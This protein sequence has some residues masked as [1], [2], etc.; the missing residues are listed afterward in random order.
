MVI[1]Y[2][3]PQAMPSRTEGLDAEKDLRRDGEKFHVLTSVRCSYGSIHDII[4]CIL[5]HV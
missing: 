3:I 5:L 4:F 1:F 2:H